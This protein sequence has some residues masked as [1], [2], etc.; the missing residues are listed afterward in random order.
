MEDLNSFSRTVVDHFESH[1]DHDPGK[2]AIKHRDVAMSYQALDRAANQVAHAI[3]SRLEHS[4]E[5]VAALFSPSLSLGIGLLATFKAAKT[6]VP[7]EPTLPEDYLKRIILKTGA[8]LVLTDEAHIDLAQRLAVEGATALTVDNLD[9]DLPDDR[10]SLSILPESLAWILHTTG[11]TGKPK[12]VTHS[13]RNLMHAD[14]RF[15]EAMDLSPSDRIMRPGS[16]MAFVGGLKSLIASLIHGCRFVFCTLDGL[17]H[18]EEILLREEITI[19]HAKPSVL[20]HL[21]DSLS[22]KESFPKLRA[23]CVAGDK[24]Y[25]SDVKRFRELFPSDCVILNQLALSEAGTVSQLIIDKKTALDAVVMSIGYPSQDTEIL[26]LD[27]QHLPV[28]IGETGEIAIKSR[29]LTQGYWDNEELTK[30]A[31][32]AGAP[33]CSERVYLTGDLGRFIED[34]GGS[35]KAQLFH[36]G[37]KD[38]RVMIRGFQVDTRQVEDELKSLI[39]IK[40]AEV[41]ALSDGATDPKLVAYIIP[42][43]HGAVNAS[44]LRRKILERLPE[45]MAP[46]AFVFL[47]A[48]PLTS[49]GKLDRSRLPRPDSSRPDLDS[50]F[51]PPV[52]VI[53]IELAAIWEKVLGV[54]SIGVNDNFFELGGHSLLGM[55]IISRARDVFNVGLYFRDLFEGSTVAKLAQ[56]IENQQNIG[57]HGDLLSP[58]LQIATES[59]PCLS[60]AQ[61]RLWFL[62][63]LDQDRAAYNV[64]DALRLEG[65]LDF[66]ALEKSINELIRKHA[67]LR[68]SFRS[69]EGKP[70]QCI[71]KSLSVR[72]RIVD[73][74]NQTES[75]REDAALSCAREEALRP[76]DLTKAPLFRVNLIRR[77]PQEH[78]LSWVSH[79]IISDAWSKEI[80]W[81]EL[82]LLYSSLLLG[83]SP[84]IPELSVQ[85]ADYAE[86]QHRHLQGKFLNEGLNYWRRELEGAPPLLDLPT[87]R[88]RPTS[89]SF[90]GAKHRIEIPESLTKELLVLNSEE[91]VT[92]F[93]TLL[94]SFQT[95]LSRY[96]GQHDI[97]VGTPVANRTRTELEGLI[98]FFTNTL[99]LRARI[100]QGD[101]FRTFLRRARKNAL[102]AYSHQEI[103]FEKLVSELNIES[104]LSRNPLFQAMFTFQNGPVPLLELT[105]LTVTRLE[106]DTGKALFDLT[107]NL[108]HTN[109][110]LSGFIEYNTDLFDTSTIR[111]MAGNFQTLLQSIAVDSDQLISE[112]PMLTE[113]ER[114]QLLVEWNDTATEYPRDKCVHQLFEEQVERKPEAIA[115]VFEERELT[116]RELNERANQLAHYLRGQG[117]GPGAHVGLCLDR[118]PDLAVGILGILKSGAAYVPLDPEFPRLRLAFILKDAGVECVI[119]QNSYCDLIPSQGLNLIFVDGKIAELEEK[120]CEDSG[121]EVDPGSLAYILFTSGSTGQPKGVA[122]P[123]RALSNLIEWHRRHPRLGK[124]SRTLQFA[125]ATFDVSFQEML[126]TWASG[127]TLVLVDKET[128]R[129]PSALLRYISDQ[130]VER[131]FVPYVALQQLA[132]GFA[133]HEGGLPLRDIVSAGEALHLTPE[134][135]LLLG[136]ADDCCLHNHYGPTESHVVTT[137]MLDHDVGNW[138]AECP[139][140]KPLA[141]TQV[142]LLDPN[143]RPAPIGVPGELYIGGAGLA[144]GY[145]NRP[146][147]TADRF[148]A[149]PFDN[150]DSDSRL[151]RSGDLC[152]W[153]ADGNLEFLGRMDDQVKLRGFRIELGEVELIISS[154][155]GVLQCVVILREDQPGE[156]RLVAYFVSAPGV[157]IEMRRLREHVQ[158]KLPEYMIPVAFVRLDSLPLTSSGKLDRRALPKPGELSKSDGECSTPKDLIELRLMQIWMKLFDRQSIGRQDNFFELGGHSL[159][160]VQLAAKV[161]K[162]LGRRLPIASLFQAPTIES[163]ANMLRDENWT[164]PWAS[165]VPLQPLGSKPPFFFVHGWGGDVF[166][167]VNLALSLAS[168]QPVYGLQSDERRSAKHGVRSVEELASHYV[169]EIRSFQAEGPYYLGGYSLGGWIAF[170]IARQLTE[171][172]QKVQM[173]AFLDTR[174]CCRLPTLMHLRL[175]LPRLAGRVGFHVRQF[176]R[177]DIAEQ[178]DYVKG[179]WTALRHILWTRLWQPAYEPLNPQVSTK[180]IPTPAESFEKVDYQALCERYRPGKYRGSIDLFKTE[181]MNPAWPKSLNKLVMGGVKIHRV[182]GDHHNMMLEPKNLPV[183][184]EA[185][186][187]A[188]EEAQ[189]KDLKMN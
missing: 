56:H 160:A 31:F 72:I 70:Y 147:L 109:D 80:L 10:P 57:H 12:G 65:P 77:G 81:R 140:G 11:S 100:L 189:G 40:E 128:R 43:E 184:A 166:V 47:D 41:T 102:E 178:V 103:P 21:L 39:E 53:E 88:P 139:I 137:M 111:R 186:G 187:N 95:L 91:G 172:G 54:S 163:L 180:T 119:T 123:H 13:H 5:M 110:F 66:A 185:F 126:S 161:E 149:N 45:Y 3:F 25:K 63:Q 167:F 52:T 29:Y 46:S 4:E 87:D 68:T 157:E 158:G 105:G 78:V 61:Q 181:E 130:Q 42:S 175:V 164:A 51:S 177:R 135:Q 131:I 62:D 136:S 2:I 34:S 8:K 176:F 86:W 124:P 154:Y 22:G 49:D 60:H 69:D 98:G 75:E 134:I 183:V 93:M 50:P 90:R 174:P 6:Y 58:M 121:S 142:Y 168:D 84:P 24:L 7:L 113:A 23:F 33:G 156:R 104:D 153:R 169:E 76:F 188:L 92:M 162:L 85:Y 106:V 20:R 97:V 28:K 71:E 120:E 155:S 173:L 143:G 74:Q 138:S 108:K 89:Q 73:L 35:G 16:T 94:A 83:E 144:C 32:L 151:Y 37:R 36:L 112:L 116:Y 79:H 107:L 27:E 159:L 59:N 9:A 141:N 55:Q 96:S 122:M 125:S 99:A 67:V 64:S 82:T 148:V 171:Q 150:D 115:V 14:M 15:T 133:G 48:F 30:K 129:D 170:E 1:V 18:P 127:G 118:S 179:R 26:L 146:E 132:I 19:F 17:S 114:H 101:T 38:Y 117:A 182:P 152:R 44:R 145:L 165:L